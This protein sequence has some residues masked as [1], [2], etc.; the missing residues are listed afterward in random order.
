MLDINNN[1]PLA[2]LVKSLTGGGKYSADLIKIFVD[3]KI[4]YERYDE[5]YDIIPDEEFDTIFNSINENN[6]KKII[7]QCLRALQGSKQTETLSLDFTN[8][9]CILHDHFT[10]T[11]TTINL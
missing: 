8:N 2:S 9:N 4:I 6:H 11:S 1:P 3:E 10:N 5:T 7:I